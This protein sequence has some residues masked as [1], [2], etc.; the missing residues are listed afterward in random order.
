MGNLPDNSL[1]QFLI[2]HGY[3]FAI[4][5]MI[6]EGPIAS[7]VMGFF[8]SF[9][10][11]NPFIV[12]LVAVISDM[13]SDSVFYAVGYLRGDDIIRRFGHYIKLSPKN[14]DV[15]K[16]FY[17]RHGG[18][19]VFFAKIMTGVVPPIFIFAGYSKMELKKF[20]TFAIMGGV[21]WSA[22]LVALGYYFGEQLDDL[23]T[24][25][26]FFGIAGIASVSLLAV[27]VLYQFKLGKILRRWLRLDF[28]GDNTHGPASP[29]H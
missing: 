17:D 28:N 29:N 9:G 15:V 21:L 11:F 1:L 27:F 6:V 26:Q 8:S 4:P 12:F 23:H 14:M 19:S 13:V 22:G 24:L 25:R 3:W 5:I 20:Y 10:Y 7:I 16:D 2:L 18:K